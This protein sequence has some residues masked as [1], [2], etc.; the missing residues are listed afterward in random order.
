MMENM[1]ILDSVSDP[2][3]IGLADPDLGRSKLAHK[4]G[5]KLMFEEFEC[6]L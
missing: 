1:A 6:S 5:K 4:K 2:N 3:S